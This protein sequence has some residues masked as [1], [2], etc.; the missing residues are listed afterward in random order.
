VKSQASEISQ[1]GIETALAIKES[2]KE[3]KL[4]CLPGDENRILLPEN[5][6]NDGIDLLSFDDPLVLAMMAV[7]DPEPPMAIAATTRMSPKGRGHRLVS[8]IFAMVG[9]TSRH[10]VVKKCVT[11]VRESAFCPETI[12]RVRS[13]ASQFVVKSRAQYTQALRR[14]LTLLVES[15]IAPSQFVKEFFELTEAGNLRNDVCKTL[16]ISLLLS[17][18]V[19]PGI[20]FLFLENLQRFPDAVCSSIISAVLGAKPSRH[21]DAVKEELGWVMAQQRLSLATH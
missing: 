6:L 10:E 8:E 11:L 9:E 19:R 5:L 3:R 7:R 4:L 16:V 14:N 20:K 21:L 15:A 12:S 1:E 13:H 2:Y 18:G 17:K